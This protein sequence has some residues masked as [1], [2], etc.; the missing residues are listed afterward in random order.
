MTG[1]DGHVA[2]ITRVVRDI[3]QQRRLERQGHQHAA[4][5]EVQRRTAAA[6]AAAATSDVQTLLSVI[7]E[8]TVEHLADGCSIWQ[9]E[10]GG[11]L[12]QLAVASRD[13]VAQAMMRQ[14]SLRLAIDAPTPAAAAFRS[15]VPT[16]VPRLDAQ[17][18]VDSVPSAHR[19]LFTQLDIR[20][21]IAVPLRTGAQTVGMLSLRRGPTEPPFDEDDLALAI[22]LA[23]RAAVAMANARLREQV[24]LELHERRRAEETAREEQDRFRQVVE[25]IHEVFWMTDVNKHELLYLSPGY[26]R[27]WGRSVGSAFGGQVTWADSIHPEDRERAVHAATK[28]ATGGY[29]ETY[30][31]VRPDGGVRWIRDRAFPIRNEAGEVFRLA[32]LAEDVTGWRQ[33]EEQ[34]RQAQKMEAIGQLAGGV[35][36]DFN[37]LLTAIHGFAFLSL[38]DQSPAS[39][40]E[41]MDQILRASERAAALT[42]QLLLFSRK[43]VMQPVAL[44]LNAVLEGVAKLLERVLGEDVTLES[45]LTPG[46][47]AVEGDPGM[48]EQVLMNLAVNARDAMPAG[49][50]LTLSTS[51]ERVDSYRTTRYPGLEAEALVVLQ[52]HDTGCGI[53]P[54]AIPH[55]FEPFFTTKEVGKGTGLGL[56]TVYG[57]VK[58][59]NG[60]ISV[61][62][63]PGKGT[64]FTI[65]L[66]AAIQPRVPAADAASA[67]RLPLGTE[68]VL[69][70]E[71]EDAVR[72]LIGH[73]LQR[74]GYTVLTAQSGVEALSVWE[75]AGGHVDLLLTDMVMPGGLSGRDLA[76][77]LR[78]Q[79]ADL[80]VIFSSGYSTE[81][82][83]TSPTLAE[84]VNFLRKPYGPDRLLK[85]VRQAL[86]TSP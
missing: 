63:E 57:I 6:F 73:L 48:I 46:L 34:Y 78:E 2:G 49:G 17:V 75:E 27:V 29:D 60:W 20:S 44:D 33:L 51:V 16:L 79:R 85:A 53:A 43:Q 84:G 62:S 10:E 86:D 56:A 77:R 12:R 68:T 24:T 14:T 18:V 64:T 69:V 41:N 80:K 76:D 71:D 50:R 15:G 59:H 23:D 61:D 13:P 30:R 32:G 9:V 70:A 28:Q 39:L 55:I 31:I 26:E 8:Q 65:R 74:S 45:L 72:L 81:F 82:G 66:P 38:R 19:P 40:A 7:A 25:N 22:D 47:P 36:H 1:H 58:Q 67:P 83:G 21:L 42:R 3:S 37:N 5:L 54:A 4:R 11:W 35:A 52:V